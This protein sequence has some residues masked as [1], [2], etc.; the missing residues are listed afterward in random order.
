VPL[1]TEPFEWFKS[2][3]KQWELRKYGRQFTE[4][5]VFT[6]RFVELRKGYST[7]QALWGTIDEVF[8]FDDLNSVFSR[9]DY[10]KIIPTVGSKEDAIKRT[11]DLLDISTTDSK[12]ISF[13]VDLTIPNIELLDTYLDLVEAGRKMTTVRKGTR[14]YE[15][16]PAVLTSDSR[17]L[18]ILVSDVN[19]KKFGDL[20]TKDAVRDGFESLED[21]QVALKEHY[22]G[23]QAT[24]PVSIVEFEVPKK[25]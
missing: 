20:S 13:K 4:K 1:S 5:H 15:L 3:Q 21:L 11:K 17:K 10:R 6:G 2:G 18:P 8:T 25:G 22:P 24:D 14:S 19:Y 16:G 12:Y 7:D 23:L 9:I